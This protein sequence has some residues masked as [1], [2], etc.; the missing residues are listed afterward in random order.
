MTPEEKLKILKQECTD[1]GL[2]NLAMVLYTGFEK[3]L[4]DGFKLKPHDVRFIED[5][6]ENRK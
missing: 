1:K 5:M 3:K 2:D 4:Q 6:W